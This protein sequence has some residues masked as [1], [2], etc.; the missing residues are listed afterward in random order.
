MSDKIAQNVVSHWQK[1]L[2]EAN[3]KVLKQKKITEELF[4]NLSNLY[5]REI[6]SYTNEEKCIGCEFKSL[7]NWIKKGYTG[8]L[9]I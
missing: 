9:D 1:L 8:S 6:C 7:E 2:D 3:E 5:C 4:K